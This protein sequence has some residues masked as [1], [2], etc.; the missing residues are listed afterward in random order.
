MDTGGLIAFERAD[1]SVVAIVA[2]A[3]E[4]GDPLVVPA[5]VVAQAWRDGRRQVRL[6]RLLG[7]SVCTVAVLDDTGARSVGQL[8]GVARTSDI[9]DASVVLTAR[10]YGLGI[11][12]SDPGDIHRLDPAIRLVVI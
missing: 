12:T 2:R 11:I 10:K 8:L 1:R 3:I 7:A 6:A 4:F 9:V 5:G